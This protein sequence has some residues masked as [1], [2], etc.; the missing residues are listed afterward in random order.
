MEAAEG[1]AASNNVCGIRFLE[2]KLTLRSSGRGDGD[3]LL[4][5]DQ[6]GGLS[7]SIFPLTAPSFP[8]GFLPSYFMT[9]SSTGHC[10]S[11]V[12]QHLLRNMDLYPPN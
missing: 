2:L 5:S 8:T 12:T 10:I 3:P 9:C 7:H 6:S 11:Q 1:L 4:L